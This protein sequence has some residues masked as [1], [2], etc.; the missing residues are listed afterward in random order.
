MTAMRVRD[1]A[2]WEKMIRDA[3]AEKGTWE[4]AADHLRV[5]M[6]TIFRWKRILE[7][8]DVAAEDVTRPPRKRRKSPNAPVHQRRISP[9]G[10]ERKLDPTAWAATIRKA[11][12]KA[13]GDV[14][15]AAAELEVHPRTL[16]R[17]L[18]DPLLDD[19]P[20][21]SVGAPPRE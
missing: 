13:D 12:G 21:K 19:V 18:G 3:V 9:L 8:D 6:R 7:G 20:R 2:G 17:W 5:S 15:A 4:A 16:W 14:H 10:A 11:M 1:R